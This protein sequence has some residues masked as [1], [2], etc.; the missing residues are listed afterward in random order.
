MGGQDAFSERENANE[1][2]FLSIGF[3]N[4]S[5]IIDAAGIWHICAS[6]GEQPG[7]AAEA[8]IRL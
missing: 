1:T 8:T 3:V 2:R 7:S 4:H 5:R 6:P